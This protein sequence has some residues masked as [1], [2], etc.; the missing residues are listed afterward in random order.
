MRLLTKINEAAKNWERTRDPFF[1][2]EWY[3]L[4]R[5]WSKLVGQPKSGKK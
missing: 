3:R 4:I 5:V 2:K 1:K